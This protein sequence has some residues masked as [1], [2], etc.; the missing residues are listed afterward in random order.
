MRRRLR[1]TLLVIQGHGGM[2]PHIR[3]HWPYWKSS[4]LDMLCIDRLDGK[5]AW[6][7][8]VPS[9]SIGRSTYI[10]KYTG[11]MNRVLIE[12]FRYCLDSPNLSDC[13]DFMMIDYD[14]VIVS[15]PPVHPGHF[16]STLAA[17]CPPDWG[18]KSTRC[19]GT[20]WWLDRETCRRFVECGEAMLSAGEYDSGA[21]DCY[22]GLILD[23][24]GI[25]FVEVNA[26]HANTLDMRLSSI[27][28]QCR[29]AVL[30]GAW[31]IHGFRD[32]Q[33]LDYVLGRIPASVVKNVILN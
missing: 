9:V 26:F 2:E 19:F 30:R 28:D 15:K 20:P 17:Y 12:S 6:P 7:D 32:E 3:R 21:P 1:K 27:L 14:A 22:C 11:N 29:L 18:T 25:P 10:E 23:R 33:H 24:T 31:I 5:V 8:S 4:G 13:T 16:A